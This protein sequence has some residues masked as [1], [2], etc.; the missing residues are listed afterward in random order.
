MVILRAS[1]GVVGGASGSTT[2][3][4]A[5]GGLSASAWPVSGVGV[6]GDSPVSGS[7]VDVALTGVRGGVEGATSVSATPVDEGASSSVY[8]GVSAVD[9]ASA[10][11][12]A[13][14][15]Y[16]SKECASSD[17]AGASVS[18]TKAERL[19]CAS[20]AQVCIQSSS[21]WRRCSIKS[22]LNA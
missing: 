14:G 1:S 15:T 18:S 7:E 22:S 4:A 11:E 13:L 17:P 10:C 6:A 21:S 19:S 5:E 3:S 16:G 9:T 20:A 2:V 8:G 12:G